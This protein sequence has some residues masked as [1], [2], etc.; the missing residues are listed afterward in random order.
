MDKKKIELIVTGILVLV[1]VL[2]LLNSLKP[3]RGRRRSSVSVPKP[4]ATPN[5]TL[6]PPVVKGKGAAR[7][8]SAKELEE[9]KKRA[10]L[11][12]GIDPFYHPIRKEIIGGSN[13]V[14]KGISIGKGRKGYA[15]I[16]DEIV[17]EGEKIAGYEVVKVE[18]D[19]VLLKKGQESFYLVLPEE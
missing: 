14:L 3:K 8:A 7:E 12:W 18:K 4:A 16:N 2:V 17:S 15:C 6:P 5:V 1:F 13:L 9:Q 11:D 19:R 10:N